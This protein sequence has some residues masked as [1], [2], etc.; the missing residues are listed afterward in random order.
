MTRY[1]YES[2]NFDFESFILTLHANGQVR[3]RPYYCSNVEVA[4][5]Y[6]QYTQRVKREVYCIVS[7]IC[8]VFMLRDG[9][10]LQLAIGLI[11][12]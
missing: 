1:K 12:S 6:W 2:Q 11:F 4:L 5:E 8:H 10:A 9:F 3:T 7:Q